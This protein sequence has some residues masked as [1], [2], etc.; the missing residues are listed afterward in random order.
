MNFKILEKHSYFNTNSLWIRLD[1]LQDLL[2][3]ENGVLPLP[4]IQNKKTVDP[5]D[6]QSTQVYQLET[7]MGAAIE[8]FPGSA[9]VCVPRSRFAR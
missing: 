2:E 3:K 5:R 7:A 6:S 1:A 9:A 4:M 8:S